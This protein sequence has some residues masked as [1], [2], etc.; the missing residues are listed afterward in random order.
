MEETHHS[1]VNVSIVNEAFHIPQLG[2]DRRIWIYKP[3]IYDT[4]DKTYPVIYMQD[5]QNLFDEGTAFGE[6]WGI[7]ETLN[8]LSAECIVVGID[9]AETRMTE[10]NFKDHEE[11]G[12]G[13]GEK[14]IRFIVETLKPYIDEN[15]KTNPAREHTHIAGSSMGG[16]VSLYAAM[17]FAETF[18]GAG[19]FS[20]SLWLVPDAPEEFKRLAEKNKEL[21]QRFYFYGGAQEGGDMLTHINSMA[22]MLHEFPQYT[23]DLHVDPLGDHSEY[24]WR[25]MFQSYYTWL[26]QGNI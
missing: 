17:Y 10:Y 22:K 19:I 16:L 15:F 7:D 8:G 5:G 11:Y 21:P 3:A 26:T 20:P 13:E 23:I 1:A 24:R 9:N 6:E 14:Y 18:G 25:N 2:R 4:S 12:A